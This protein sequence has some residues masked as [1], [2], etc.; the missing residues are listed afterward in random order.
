MNHLEILNFIKTIRESFYG[1]EMIYS[2]GSCY[3]FYLIL[4]NIDNNAI[5]YFKD[6]H[7]VTKI[8]NKYYDIYG[9]KIGDF[10]L[11]D[12]IEENIK[13]SIINNKF[14]YNGYYECPNCYEHIKIN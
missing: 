9:E 1:S 3:Q 5:A 12:N 7:I 10:I 8:N 14:G 2:N 6:N 4:K 13:L 11:F